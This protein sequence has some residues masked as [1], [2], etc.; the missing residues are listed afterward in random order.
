MST[1]PNKYYTC[2]FFT[3][4]IVKGTYLLWAQNLVQNPSF[5]GF[6]NC[7]KNL[8]NLKDDLVD[9]NIPT[10]GSTDYFNGCSEAMGTPKNFNGEQ[11]AD[12]GVG[13][14]GLYLYA[15][16]DYREYLQ[17]RLK[18]KLIKDEVYILSFY[19]SLAERSEFA[20]KEFG[21]LFSEEPIDVETNKVLSRMH[22]SKLS[23]DASNSFEISYADFYSDNKAWVKVEKDFVAQGTEN[24]IVIGNFKDNK[25][26]HKFNTKR[27]DTK[28]SYYYLDMVAVY[29]KNKMLHNNNQMASKTLDQE[30]SVNKVNT[31]KSLLFDFDKFEISSNFKT[32]L[33]RIIT[34]LKSNPE[35]SISINGHT[36]NIGEEVYNILLSRKRAETVAHFILEQGIDKTRVVYDG[37][38]SSQPL[39]SNKTRRGRNTNRRVEFVFFSKN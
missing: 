24:H 4:L 25:R 30:F 32:E 20:I 36:D 7:P 27:G 26:T 39:N 10:L 37:F 2:L 17:G 23:G 31:F 12:F 3:I 18:E 6:V 9:W 22:L 29:P 14:V 38:G 19:V 28:G 13:Y 11:P 8:G 34:Y 5:E 1:V 33:S 15:P 21:I 35:L 16:N